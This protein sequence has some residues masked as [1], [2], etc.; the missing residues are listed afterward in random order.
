MA[1]KGTVEV[2]PGVA[3]QLELADKELRLRLVVLA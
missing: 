1:V 2:R 3:Y